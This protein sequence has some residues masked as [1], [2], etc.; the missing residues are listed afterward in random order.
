MLWS[1]DFLYFKKGGEQ[2][3]A[4][5]EKA[6]IIKDIFF[7]S[8]QCLCETLGNRGLYIILF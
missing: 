5:K 3:K 1:R 8:C 2:N 6:K 7:G 4:K